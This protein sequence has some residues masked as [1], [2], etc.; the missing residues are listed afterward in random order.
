MGGAAGAAIRTGAAD[1]GP[2]PGRSI[3]QLSTKAAR[4]TLSSTSVVQYNRRA[5]REWRS[6]PDACV[7]PYA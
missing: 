6:A 2:P 3:P 4:S 1:G 5:I 7:R